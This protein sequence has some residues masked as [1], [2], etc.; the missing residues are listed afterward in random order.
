M[1]KQEYDLHIINILKGLI[2]KYGT[3]EEK[4]AILQED[5]KKQES[6]E[7]QQ[8]TLKPDK[9]KFLELPKNIQ[10]K[11]LESI[12]EENLD[13]SLHFYDL[14]GLIKNKCLKQFGLP[15]ITLNDMVLNNVTQAVI[16]VNKKGN[17]LNIIANKEANSLFL[18]QII[19][20]T[21]EYK[22][23]KLP[24]SPK[25]ANRLNPN[26]SMKKPTPFE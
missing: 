2:L 15:N 26:K 21:L 12:P 11:R 24:L 23:K 14:F 20:N 25:I 8:L 19:N 3:E 6:I 4:E 22:L 10:T 5:E 1:I 16:V 9:P 7:I 17:I 13:N 18:S